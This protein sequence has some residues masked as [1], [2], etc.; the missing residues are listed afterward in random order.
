MI[1]TSN[2]K[3]SIKLIAQDEVGSTR[4][5]ELHSDQGVFVG[6]SANCGLQ[7][8][9]EGI[10]D[11]HCRIGFEEG[12]LTVQDW[13]SSGTCVNGNQI[14]S[15]ADIKEGDVVQIGAHKISVGARNTLDSKPVQS[16]S[17]NAIQE[18]GAQKQATFQSSP[19]HNPESGSSNPESGSSNPDFGSSEQEIE[20][21]E[22]K[23]GSSATE[24][25]VSTDGGGLL[26]NKSMNFETDFSEWEEEQTFDRETVDLLRAEI[27]E[28]QAALVQ[29]DARAFDGGTLEFE[30]EPTDAVDAGVVEQRIKELVEDANRSDERVALLEEMLHA[31]E[32]SNRNELEERNQLQAWV[33]EIESRITQRE[34]ESA[35]E[36]ETLHLRLEESQQAQDQLRRK[37]GQA[38]CGGNAP[39]QYEETLENLQQ[40]NH[41]LQQKLDQ[42]QKERHVLKQQLEDSSSQQESDIREERANIAKE[43]ARLSRLRFELSSKVAD[44][45][46]LPK[47]A[48]E[49]EIENSGKIQA[50]REHLREIHAQEKR[51]EVEVSLTSRLAKL[52]KRV[53]Y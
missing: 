33:S 37:L 21:S 29:Q 51:D 31:A 14:E 32:D 6:Q 7:L 41:E 47:E 48:N 36:I 3:F 1:A 16:E 25:D 26:G 5:F 50:L 19:G 18:D 10:G 35:A 52:W 34:E 12:K 11:I 39:R 4:S 30:P 49:S 43:Q 13:M 38:A 27:E 28:L 45:E 2:D 9:G 40:A 44:V 17:C 46:S 24:S 53:E 8:R 22:P 20:S 23:F 42:S 15:S